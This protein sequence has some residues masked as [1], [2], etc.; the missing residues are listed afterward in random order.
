MSFVVVRLFGLFWFEFDVVCIVL[1][2][3]VLLCV[4]SSCFVMFVLWDVAWCFV[5]CQLF[6]SCVGCLLCCVVLHVFC[7]CFVVSW[8]GLLCVAFELL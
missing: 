5:S 3:C 6:M 4:L 1:L 8:F 2:C 7:C